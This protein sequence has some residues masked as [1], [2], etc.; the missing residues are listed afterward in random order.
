MPW[1]S[2]TY[3]EVAVLSDDTGLKARNL[4]RNFFAAQ[5]I[6][7][8]DRVSFLASENFKMCFFTRSLRKAET[9]SRAFAP[10]RARGFRLKRTLLARGD[11][12]DKWKTDYRIMPLAKK[13][14]LVPAWQR[15]RFK[16]GRRIPVYLDPL[17]AFGTGT[18]ET[19]RLVILLMECLEGQFRSFLD[20]GTGTGILSVAASKLGAVEILGLDRERASVKTARINLAGNHCPGATLCACDIRK[21]RD[22]RHFDLVAANLLSETLL[23]NKTKILSRVRKG[24]FLIASG[25]GLANLES[26]R[27]E[28]RAP[29]LRCVKVLRGRKWAAILFKKTE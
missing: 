25:I 26:F 15:S 24:K 20:I 27:K 12:L 22:T 13:F 6:P 23:A 14:M 16:G 2:R 5:K 8:R 19:T 18:H 4:C 1:D 7:P 11:W 29:G 28:F 21:F 10:M 9:I 3:L 17:S